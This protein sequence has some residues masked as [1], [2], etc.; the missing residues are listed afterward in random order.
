MVMA[1][2][3]GFLEMFKEVFKRKPKLAEKPPEEK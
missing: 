3:K 1:E 2:K